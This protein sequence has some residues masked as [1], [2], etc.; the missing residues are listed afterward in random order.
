M[1]RLLL[2]C[3]TM[4][5][6]LAAVQVFAQDRTVSGRVTSAEDGSALPGVS[7]V[8]KGTAIGTQTDG[9]GRY[10]LSVPAAG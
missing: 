4:M 5:L 9:E 6:M 2:S 10:S 8:L 3:V 7:V 1:K